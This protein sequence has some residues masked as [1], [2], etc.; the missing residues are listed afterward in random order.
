MTITIFSMKNG[1]HFAYGDKQGG[2]H[3][4]IFKGLSLNLQRLFNSML[5]IQQQADEIGLTFF[6]NPVFR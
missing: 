1:S 3:F 5:R 4:C 2:C 6:V